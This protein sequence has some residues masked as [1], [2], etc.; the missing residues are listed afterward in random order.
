MG[1]TKRVNTLLD[2]YVLQFYDVTDMAFTSGTDI[3]FISGT[4]MAF[5][6]VQ[7]WNGYS[8]QFWNGYTFT[9]ET[10]IVFN[11][12]FFRTVHFLKF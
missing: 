7:F 4:N 10:D 3:A 11:L 2:G 8:L 9:S 1:L 6:S 12:V 5:S